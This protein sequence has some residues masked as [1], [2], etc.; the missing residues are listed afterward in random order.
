MDN[1]PARKPDPV[2]RR[3]LIIGGTIV[4]LAAGGGSATADDEAERPAAHNVTRVERPEAPPATSEATPA[5]A[6]D[7]DLAARL[8]RTMG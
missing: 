3:W 5:R 4:A 7:G 8:S 6:Q 2:K 1:Q